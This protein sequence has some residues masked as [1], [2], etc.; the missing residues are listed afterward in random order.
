MK[1][2]GEAITD[3]VYM[4]RIIRLGGKNAAQWKSYRM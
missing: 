3:A 1:L 4:G 2:R